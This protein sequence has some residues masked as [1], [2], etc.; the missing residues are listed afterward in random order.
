MLLQLI[1]Q[2]MAYVATMMPCTRHHP[3]APAKV[4]WI[5]AA[6]Q[7]TAAKARSIRLGQREKA[8]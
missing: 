2:K 4:V 6:S 3:A 7:G 1:Q 5:K 8:C